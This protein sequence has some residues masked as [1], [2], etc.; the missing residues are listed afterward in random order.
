M[1][2]GKGRGVAF[3]L[4]VGLFGYFWLLGFAVLGLLARQDD[5]VRNVLVAPALGVVVLI[6]SLYVPSRAGLAIGSVAVPI[7]GALFVGAIAALLWRR[8]LLPGRR[9]LPYLLL[10][11]LA[12]LASGWPL[13]TNGFAWLGSFNPDAANY[14]LSAARLTQRS[15]IEVADPSVWRQQS[16]WASYT[17]L[18][19]LLGSRT[20]TDLVFAWTVSVTGLD[21]P[22]AYMPLILSWHVAALSAAAALIAARDRYARLLSAAL[23]AVAALSTSGVTSQLLGQELGLTC[24]GLVSVFLLSPFYRLSRPALLR[25]IALTSLALAGF[26]LSYPE[27]LPFC[28]F[29]CI[30]YHAMNARDFLRHWRKVTVTAVATGAVALLL[31][32]PDGISL[33]GFLFRQTTIAIE[34]KALPSLFP[35]FLT[36]SGAPVL[37]GLS[38]LGGGGPLP[39]GVAVAIGLLL[40]VAA[41]A[42]ALWLTWRREA[43]AAIV[44]VMMS[45]AVF[46]MLAQNGFG[47]FKLAMYLQPF[48][49]PMMVLALCRLLRVAR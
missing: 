24:F 29:A 42:A 25:Y 22:A 35:F 11:L 43:T 16:D 19:P 32:A 6:Y 36:P 18:F 33:I 30:L 17:V 48:L 3:L 13:F 47:T 41:I 34:Q 14:M 2:E 8:P 27:M 7:G 37:W 44:L 10:V 21:E 45:M 9:G 46:L 31:I 39:A 28:G 5:L 38:N 40:G 15:F 1:S 49:M 23:L 26:V 20:A 4:A 12:F